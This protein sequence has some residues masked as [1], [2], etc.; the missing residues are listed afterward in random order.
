MFAFSSFLLLPQ[1]EKVLETLPAYCSNAW[2]AKEFF[3]SRLLE[4][5][6]PYSELENDSTK[7]TFLWFHSLNSIQVGWR[8]GM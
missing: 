2:T 7:S 3:F 4:L 6:T 8:E 1:W 5:K